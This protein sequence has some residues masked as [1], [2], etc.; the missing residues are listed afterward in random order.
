MDLRF[1]TLLNMIFGRFHELEFEYVLTT[2]WSLGICVSGFGLDIHPDNK[3]KLL[4][5]L[6]TTEVPAQHISNIPSL[7]FSISCFFDADID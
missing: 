4:E 3:Q 1:T 5:A 7:A 2:I 6:Q